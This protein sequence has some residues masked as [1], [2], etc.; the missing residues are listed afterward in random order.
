MAY[1]DKDQLL[2]LGLRSPLALA[3]RFGELLLLLS[4]VAIESTP[5]PLNL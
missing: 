4:L 2:L 3:V 5:T 1:I